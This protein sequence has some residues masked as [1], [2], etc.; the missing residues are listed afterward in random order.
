MELHRTTGQSDWATVTPEK[1][2][3]WQR[4]AARSN[5]VVTPA[6]LLTLAGFVLVIVGLHAVADKQYWLGLLFIVVGRLLDIA[7]GWVAQATGTKSPL[8][9]RLDVISDKAGIILAL[10][11]FVAVHLASYWLLAALILPQILL[12]IITTITYRQGRRLH[13]SVIGKLGIA[14]TSASLL[15]LILIK[16]LAPS[17][18][19]FSDIVY[20]LSVVAM[21]MSLY[22]ASQYSVDKN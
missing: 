4:L 12:P 11:I 18:T 22:A 1:R 2:N 5:S 8:G 16:A 14:A 13:P 21:A 6:N 20:A 7:D 9:E 19:W 10:I 3:G 17:P 15:G